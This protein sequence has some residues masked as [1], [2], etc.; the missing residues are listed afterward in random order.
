MSAPSRSGGDYAYAD[1]S[2]YYKLAEVCIFEMCRTQSS[3]SSFDFLAMSFYREG[4]I[5]LFT[6]GGESMFRR[7]PHFLGAVA[8]A[9]GAGVVRLVSSLLSVQVIELLGWV[10]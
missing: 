4:K 7:P 6:I 3:R 5:F 9:G 2:V 1:I 10:L 8:P